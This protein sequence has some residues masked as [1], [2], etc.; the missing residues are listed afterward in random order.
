MDHVPFEGSY[1]P[2][3][4]HADFEGSTITPRERRAFEALFKLRQEKDGKAQQVD[5]KGADKRDRPRSEGH[6]LDDII[7][8]AGEETEDNAVRSSHYPKP[9]QRMAREAQGQRKDGETQSDSIAAAARRDI[10]HV[11]NLI[12]QAKTDIEIWNILQ[13]R[14]FKRV[15]ALNLDGPPNK[16]SKTVRKNQ[17]AK[18]ADTSKTPFGIP[19]IPNVTDLDV[20]AATLP[21][22]LTRTHTILTTHFPN[23]PLPLTLLPHLRTLGPAAFALCTSTQLYNLHMS[24]LFKTHLD[25]DGIVDTLREMD[26]QVYDFDEYTEVLIG[27]IIRHARLAR[28]GEWGEGV[29]R[30]W[31][32]EGS[33]KRV[34]RIVRLGNHVRARREE[35]AL[36]RARMEEDESTAT[37]GEAEGGSNGSR[38]GGGVVSYH[39]VL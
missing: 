24:L 1:G 39:T 13:K 16:K 17:V 36:R 35:A 12:D 9:L 25:L 7:D 30:L 34:G 5:E 32:G 38:G 22:H 21:H 10:R 18:E 2:Q 26:A 6:L 11:N 33:R 8:A 14:V 23:S 15:T 31:S 3:D 19:P 27:K 29:K 37:D 28:Q 20:V 4:V